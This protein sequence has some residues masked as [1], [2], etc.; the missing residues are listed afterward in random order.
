VKI[1]LVELT[2]RL[3]GKLPVPFVD[4]VGC[5]FLFSIPRAI[6]VALRGG[7]EKLIAQ[8]LAVEEGRLLS[9]KPPLRKVQEFGLAQ[10]RE[11]IAQVDIGTGV[12]TGILARKFGVSFAPSKL[13]KS[14]SIPKDLIL[15]EY[16]TLEPLERLLNAIRLP[17]RSIGLEYQLNE[18]DQRLSITPTASIKK[19]AA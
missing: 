13:S 15:P 4:S 17:L 2:R 5:F 18:K 19:S 3:L 9:D 11:N 12:W 7:K 16:E 6:Y 10:F 1:V 14:F 8:A